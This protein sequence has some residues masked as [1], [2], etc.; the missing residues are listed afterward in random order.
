MLTHAK[1]VGA[2]SFL[3]SDLTKFA[4]PQQMSARGE[5]RLAA[6]ARVSLVDEY[7]RRCDMPNQN[8]KRISALAA[9]KAAYVRDF[10]WPAPASHYHFLAAKCSCPLWVEATFVDCFATITITAIVVRP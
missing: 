1:N 10:S 5:R 7:A 6:N 2:N 8:Q 4:G 3:N 9:L